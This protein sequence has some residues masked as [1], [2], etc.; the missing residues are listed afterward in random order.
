MTL[1]TALQWNSKAE[2]LQGAGDGLHAQE[3][4]LGE[5]FGHNT[6]AELPETSRPRDPSKVLS[7]Q[8]CTTNLLTGSWENEH[9]FSSSHF[10]H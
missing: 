10:W 1:P 2:G 4:V 8:N 7:A 3:G 5:L 9:S 6:G